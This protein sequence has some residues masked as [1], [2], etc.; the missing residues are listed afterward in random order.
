MQKD[1]LLISFSG[2]RTSA[3]MA[4]WIKNEW[5]DRYKYEI[6][7]VFANTGKEK[8]ATL[9]FVEKCDKLWNLGV[10]W[11]EAIMFFGLI[12][13]G[14]R[15]TFSLQNYERVVRKLKKLGY[16]DNFINSIERF[17][18]P[19]LHKVVEFKTASR[20]GKP[21][22]DTI[23]KY[24]IPNQS[25]PH[26]TRVMKLVPIQSFAKRELGWE[27]YFTAIGIR[28]DEPQRLN[29]ERA[30]KERL[31]YPLALNNPKTKS[32]IAL[33]WSKQPFN[34]ELKSFE[35]NCDFCW[36]KAFRKLMTIHKENPEIYKWWLDMEKKYENYTPP[37]RSEKSKPPYR[38]FRNGTSVEE[39]IEESTFPF[40]FAV[41][42]SNDIDKW[43]QTSLWNFDLDS[44]Y[45][46]TES[47]E[48]F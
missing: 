37:S 28:K 48:V 39:I 26:C 44:N 42:E 43:K 15:H 35:G 31:L 11:V 2:G 45:G 6:A 5:K 27:K 34:L 23:K 9:E 18:A 24:G 25:F 33:F 20:N 8:E 16:T 36:K 19:A 7:V 4:Y 29:W 30:K 22:E 17:D 12:I 38:F 32:D 46:C 3:Y 14:K 40:E 21:F 10:V 47:C 13:N 41:D 1:K